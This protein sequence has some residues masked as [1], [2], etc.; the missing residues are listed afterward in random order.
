[1]R[2]GPRGAAPRGADQVP[3][4]RAEPGHTRL[5]STTLGQ[6]EVTRIAY[7]HPGVSNAPGR[8]PQDGT[9]APELKCCIDYLT[10]KQ[11]YLTHRITLAMGW[12]IATGVVEG[13]CR[14]LVEDRLVITGA[15][16]SLP[17][18][19]AALLLGAVIT[20]GDFDAYW[21]YH[22]QQEHQRT[23]TSRYQYQYDLAA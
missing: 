16:W 15:R 1:L 3:R 11:P 20:N 17:G 21:K 10:A 9:T 13:T 23:H 4:R 5:L 7:R 6:V 22:L 19:E 18:A 8:R 14:Y 2:P 12:P